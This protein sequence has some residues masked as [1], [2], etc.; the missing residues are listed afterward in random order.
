MLEL[1]QYILNFSYDLPMQVSGGSGRGSGSSKERA[2]LHP[3]LATVE[4]VAASS[5]TQPL[6]VACQ[7]LAN[8]AVLHWI[9]DQRESPPGELL[10]YFLALS[11]SLVNK[12]ACHRGECNTSVT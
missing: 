12:T 3:V 11:V 6:M 1:S 2:V 7:V 9:V 4:R 8:H 5:S 10:C